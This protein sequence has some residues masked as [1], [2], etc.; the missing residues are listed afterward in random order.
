MIDFFLQINKNGQSRSAFEEDEE[1]NFSSK[2]DHEKCENLMAQLLKKVS[3][4][5]GFPESMTNLCLH[6]HRLPR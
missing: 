5:S 2:A 6:F 1:L 4:L 3:W